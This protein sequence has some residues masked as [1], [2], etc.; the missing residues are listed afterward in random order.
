MVCDLDVLHTTRRPS[1]AHAIL[2]V[3]PNAVLSDA[4]ALQCFQLKPE[5]RAAPLR[6]RSPI[7]STPARDELPRL[8][9]SDL[10]RPEE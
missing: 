9:S 1:E 8:G 7:L 2:F 3:D 5:L 4:I 10:V 6:G